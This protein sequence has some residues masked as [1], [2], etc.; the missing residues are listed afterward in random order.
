M[1]GGGDDDTRSYS[2]INR[3]ESK[4]Q[5]TQWNPGLMGKSR[6]VLAELSINH[7]LF[8]MIGGGGGGE[9]EREDRVGIGRM[10]EIERFP[11]I[12]WNKEL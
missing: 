9:F 6:L 4:L 11:T 10:R 1:R 12:P 5:V 8:T 3:E 7:R 2:R